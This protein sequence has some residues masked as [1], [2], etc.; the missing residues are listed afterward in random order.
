MDELKIDPEFVNGVG[1]VPEAN[2]YCGVIII[3]WP[4]GDDGKFCELR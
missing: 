3:F 4:S 1:S 2:V